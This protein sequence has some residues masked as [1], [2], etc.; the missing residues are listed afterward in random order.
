MEKYE[1]EILDLIDNQEEYTR[2]DLQGIVSVLVKKIAFD[3]S[4]LDFDTR[5]NRSKA[6]DLQ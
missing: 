5:L 1:N 4:L 2:S 3:E 6:Y